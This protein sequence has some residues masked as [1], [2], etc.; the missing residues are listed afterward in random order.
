MTYTVSRQCKLCCPDTTKVQ[1][2]EDNLPRTRKRTVLFGADGKEKEDEEK[3]EE[4]PEKTSDDAKKEG[5]EEN[6]EL[7]PSK[8]AETAP[9]VEAL[10]V[11]DMKIPVFQFSL[12]RV[13]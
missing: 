2:F 8:Q 12:S 9:E 11:S 1:V 3:P 4:Q 6:N 10:C 13:G 5:L 7:K